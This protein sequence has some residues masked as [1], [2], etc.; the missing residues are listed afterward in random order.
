MKESQNPEKREHHTETSSFPALKILPLIKTPRDLQKLN[1]RQLDRLAG[2]IRR[3]LVQSVAQTGGH[4]GPNL[5][6]VE[7]TI[8]LHRIFDVS[9]DVFVFDTGHQTYVHKLLTGRQDF[10]HLRQRGGLSGY[11]SRA[12]SDTDV[13][14]NSHA[15]AS[16]AWADGIARANRLAGRPGWVVAVIGDGAFTGGMAWEALNNIAAENEGRLLIVLNDNGRSYAPT[17]GGLA[18]HLDALRVT[19]QYEKA[20]KWGKQTLRGSGPVG[21]LVYSGLHAAKAGL[22]DMVSPAEGA[23]FDEL[24]ITYTGPVDGHDIAALEFSFT[25]VLASTKPVLIHVIT[26][27][28]RG[29]TPAETNISDHFHAIGRIHPETG[30]PIDPERFE[31][32]QVFADE[33]LHLARR[34]EKIVAL[35]AAMLQPVGLLPFKKQFPNRVFDVG[36]AEADAMA[37]A[38][39]L[40]Y[41]GYHPVFAVYSTFLNRAYDQLLMDVAL[42]HAGVTICEDRSGVTGP[43]GASHNGVW[44]IALAATVPGL[45]LAAPRDEATLRDELGE[46]V[47]VDN[48]PTIVRYPKGSLPDP[49]PAL[50]REGSMDVLWESPAGSSARDSTRASQSNAEDGATDTQSRGSGAEAAPRLLIAATGAF[51]KLGMDVGESLAGDFNVKVIDP[52]WLLPVASD[53]VRASAG[54]DWVVTLEDG[55]VDGGFGS[56]IRNR[57]AESNVF[58]PVL[59]YGIPKQFLSHAT[60]GEILE[61]LGL[62]SEALVDSIR[63]R[64]GVLSVQKA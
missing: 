64:T 47:L 45:R 21:N 8:A 28:G 13:L 20:L 18:H 15:S 63:S 6:V 43:D 42:H 55:L 56:Q 35:T 40:A 16:L 11:P 1:H 32:T 12:E 25:R 59:S 39:G 22:R 27:K 34:D 37:T 26:Q 33:I 19:P 54:Y 49:I 30:L 50:R 29:Y 5:G 2:E 46:A 44:D 38:A 3:F 9:R 62:T 58:T 36:I 14:E 4:L 23:L 53:L 51:A 24:G 7:L 61:E 31:W 48:A 10:S 17:I 52:R 41:G 60:R 57:L